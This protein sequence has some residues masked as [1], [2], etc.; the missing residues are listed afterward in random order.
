MNIREIAQKAEVSTAT[1]SRVLNKSG[2]VKEETRQRVQQI[3]REQGYTPSAVAQSLSV[4][5]THNIGFITPDIP[6]PFSAKVLAGVTQVAEAAN[7]NVFVFN[8]DETPDKE[9][10]ILGIVKQQRLDGIII[11]PVKANDNLTRE[12]LEGLSGQGI[13]VVQFDRKLQNTD[14]SSVLADNERGAYLA[15][16]KLIKE[17][18]RQIGI[19]EGDTLN[20]AV[21]ERIFG[22]CK[23]L[24]EADIPIRSEYMIP[25]DQ[26]IEKAYEAARRLMEL[27]NPPTAIFTCNNFMTL[28]CIKYFTE[29]GIVIGKDVSLF[30]FDDIDTLNIVGYK[31]SVVE[32]SGFEMGRQAMEILMHMLE[33]KGVP[34][35]HRRLPVDVILRGSEKIEKLIN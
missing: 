33:E 11:S 29:K 8:S 22:Y 20:W 4:R 7:Y 18:H 32:Q 31:V 3:I 19:V 21:K 2:Y 23:A 6:N 28:G 26:R 17:G 24:V 34:N 27:P 5:K 15:V 16:S 13:P 9:R 30:G 1:V 14:L 12:I 25:G 10:K 35:E